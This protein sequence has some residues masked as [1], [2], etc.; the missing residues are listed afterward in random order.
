MNDPGS[1][2][3]QLP[4][5]HALGAKPAGNLTVIR[6]DPIRNPAMHPAAERRKRRTRLLPQR[7]RARLPAVL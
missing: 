5:L 3:G 7:V 2:A 6:P 4:I 1:I